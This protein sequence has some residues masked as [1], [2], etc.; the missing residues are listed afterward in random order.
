MVRRLGARLAFPRAAQ[1]L[2]DDTQELIRIRT[3]HSQESRLEQQQ[4]ACL[5]Q[6]LC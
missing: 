5:Q 3:E 1:K 4:Q 6:A 2:G